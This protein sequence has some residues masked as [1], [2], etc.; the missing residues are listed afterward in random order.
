M[1]PLTKSDAQQHNHSSAA[2]VNSIRKPSMPAVL[3]SGRPPQALPVFDRVA[4][5]A[6]VFSPPLP[7]LKMLASGQCPQLPPVFDP[8][9]STIDTFDPP[10]PKVKVLASG[11]R[12]AAP[13]RFIPREH[14]GI[15][16]VPAVGLHA[17]S[18]DSA[19][20]AETQLLPDTAAAGAATSPPPAPA[21]YRIKKKPRAA[22]DS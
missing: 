15:Q 2:R 1:V 11:H 18:A 4:H 9:Y 19:N 17:V 22:G 3:S 16:F 13:S 12:P 21:R 20:S 5:T 14:S 7:K 6:L 8:F 10:L